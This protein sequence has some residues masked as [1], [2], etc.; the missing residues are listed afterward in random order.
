MNYDIFFISF[1]ESNQEHNWQRVLELH[2]NAI[3]LHGIK[4]IDKVHLLCN[5]ISTSEWFWTVDGDNWLL[6]K[7]KWEEYE[8]YVY[9]LMFHAIDPITTEWTQLGGV[10]LWRRNSFV[11]TDMSLGD[12]CLNAVKEK[13]APLTVLSRTDYNNTAYEAWKTAFRHC[14]KLLSGIIGDRPLAANKQMYIDRWISCQDFDN[15]TNNGI[16]AYRGFT[17]AQE[18]VNIV[19]A[20]LFKINDYDWLV[21]YYK[22]KYVK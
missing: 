5:Q 19:N 15:G 22:S 14:V 18:Y 12:F 11:N 20:D 3:R 9:L 8:E 7:L 17:D 1:N 4:G 2:P 16:W 13:R 6:D 21:S 10:K